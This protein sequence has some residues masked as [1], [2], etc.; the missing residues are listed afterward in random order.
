MILGSARDTYFYLLKHN[1]DWSMVAIYP[2]HLP[3][4]QVRVLTG[5]PTIMEIIGLW[6]RERGPPP[7]YC[8]PAEADN[9]SSPDPAKFPTD[10]PRI[11]SSDPGYLSLKMAC[12]LERINLVSFILGKLR[13]VHRYSSCLAVRSAVILPQLAPL[14]SGRVALSS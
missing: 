4:S 13:V 3:W 9:P 10:R 11:A 1:L 5:P 7:T 12:Y 8:E 2:L 14:P 6:H